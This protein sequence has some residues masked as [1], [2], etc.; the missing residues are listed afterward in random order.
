M[1]PIG[2]MRTRV[3]SAGW[4][5]LALAA[6]IILVALV[7]NIN[8]LLLIGYGLLSLFII[9]V[10]LVRRLSSIEFSATVPDLIEAGLPSRATLHVSNLG[11]SM[12]RRLEFRIQMAGSMGKC[13]VHQCLAKSSVEQVLTLPAFKRDV[14][15]DAQA[16]VH[17][18]YPFGLVE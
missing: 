10:L 13:I 5:W 2:R 9:N 3:T 17:L 14:I 1:R 16:I 11:T 4:A 18:S 7:K 8:L 6:A 12:V 15:T